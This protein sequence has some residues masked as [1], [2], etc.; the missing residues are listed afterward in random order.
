MDEACAAARRADAKAFRLL[1]AAGVDVT[2]PDARCMTSPLIAAIEGQV[3]VDEALARVTDVDATLRDGRTALM[4]SPPPPAPASVCA[5]LL[6]KG[7]DASRRDMKG[8]TAV[9]VARHRATRV[10]LSCGPPTD[11]A[12][13]AAASKA[14]VD[15]LRAL[16]AKGGKRRRDGRQKLSCTRGRVRRDGAGLR[17]RVARQ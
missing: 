13:V 5:V 15:V 17:R 16:L 3:C 1:L 9:M 10:L 12:V 6:R 8:R 14:D 2:A 11:E 7:A 4:A